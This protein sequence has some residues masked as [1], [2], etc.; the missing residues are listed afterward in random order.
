MH[1]AALRIYPVKGLRGVDVPSARLERCGLAGDRRWAI[2]APNGK[3]LTQRDLPAM[4]RVDAFIEGAFLRLECAGHGGIDAHPTEIPTTVDVWRTIIPTHR[5]NPAASAWLTRALGT[6]CTL[7]HQS[8]PASRPVTPD[9]AKPGDVVS[10]ADGFPLLVTNEA[11]LD[12]LNTRLRTPVPMD[13]F[14]ANLVIAGA[15]AWAE[16]HWATIQAGSIRLRLA[17]PCARCTVTTLDQQTGENPARTEPLKT[18]GT[19]HRDTAGNI[20]FGWNA[21]PESLGTIAVG[22]TITGPPHTTP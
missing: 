1:I 2:L 5:A 11:S 20:T 15:E 17:S 3:A 13:R 12:H 9:L 21:V 7:V 16:D 6:E 19:F 14:R 4:A 18:L 22:A 10:L 8:D